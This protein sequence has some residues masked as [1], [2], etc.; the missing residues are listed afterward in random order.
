MLHYIKGTLAIKT[1]S[2][3]VVDAGGLGYEITVPA[4]SSVYLAKE[5]E[6]ITVFTA[7]IVREDDIRL[8]GFGE[9][10]ALDTFHKLITVSGVGAKAAIAILSAMPLSEVHQAIVLED[11]KS[12]TRA[13]GIGKKTAERIVLEL[14][15]KFGQLEQAALPEGMES[16]ASAD[17]AAGDS[18]TEAVSALV[19]LGY[20]KGEAVNALTA[21]KEKDLTVEE[22]IKQALKRL[23]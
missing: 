14:K 18:R 17:G 3:I 4:N 21:V 9:K 11:A 15:D 23:F 1:E 6:S 20:T 16:S 8:F 12:L 13:N 22:Y 10:A 7:M 19:A 2:G 5:G